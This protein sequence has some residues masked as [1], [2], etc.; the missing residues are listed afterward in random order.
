M[1]MPVSPDGAFSL[2]SAHFFEYFGKG[3]E[4]MPFQMENVI[5]VKLFSEGIRCARDTLKVFFGWTVQQCRL[6]EKEK[7]RKGSGKVEIM[8]RGEVGDAQ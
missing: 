3:V 4:S 5:A 8:S 1:I 2:R 7:K 6:A